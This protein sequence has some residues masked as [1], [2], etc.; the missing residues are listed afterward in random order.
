MNDEIWER[1]VG[2]DRLGCKEASVVPLFYWDSPETWK[3]MGGWKS[4]KYSYPAEEIKFCYSNTYSLK[5]V[6]K[7]GD[8]DEAGTGEEEESIV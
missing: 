2:N 6:Q 1:I 7:Y 5:T 8:G 3:V 4:Y